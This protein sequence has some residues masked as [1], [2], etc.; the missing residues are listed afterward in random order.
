[1]EMEGGG[2]NA[3][4]YGR[5]SAPTKTG[6][7]PT[8]LVAHSAVESEAHAFAELAAKAAFVC[9]SRQIHALLQSERPEPSKVLSKSMTLLMAHELRSWSK[10]AAPPKSWSMMVTSETSHPPV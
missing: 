1:M 8:R 9:Q 6:S 3:T 4:S 10:A 7:C 5:P 2:E